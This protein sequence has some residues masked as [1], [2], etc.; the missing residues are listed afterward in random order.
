MAFFLNP[1]KS[2]I[3]WITFLFA[4]AFSSIGFIQAWLVNGEFCYALDDSF[5]MMALAKNLAFHQVWGLNQ[6]EFSSTASSP[7]FTVLLAAL[8]R[9]LGTNIFI[10]LIINIIALFFIF[11]YL[12]KKSGEWGLNAWQTWILLLGTFFFMPVP[13]LLFGSMEHLVHTLFALWVLFYVF[14][15]GTNSNPLKLFFGGLLLGAVRFEAMF[16]IGLLVLWLWK[17][18][19]WFLGFL[20]GIGGILSWLVLGIYSL[21]QG[22]FFLPNSLVLKAYGMNIQETGSFFGYLKSIVFK[23]ANHPHAIAS[24]F[25]LYLLWEWKIYKNQRDK[26]LIFVALGMSA[27]HFIFAR[28]NHVYRYEAYLMGISWVVCWKLVSSL[29]EMKTSKAFLQFF[30][31]K[32]FLPVLILVMIISPIYR[33]IDSYAVGTRAMC[34]IYDQQVQMAR[35]VEKYYP[36][37]TIGVL[38]IGALAFYSDCKIMDIWGLGTM[39]FAKLKLSGHYLPLKI[40]SVCKKKGMW[41]A[42]VYGIVLDHPD[43][44]KVRSWVISN[45]AVCSRERITFVCLDPKKEQDLLANLEAFEKNLPVSVKVSPE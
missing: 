14:E 8:F 13:V 16:E 22:W 15:N 17:E 29:S 2:K 3:T 26:E 4:L 41:L 45:N 24:S 19:A 23:A 7:F 38:D 27:M 33:S 43:W 10:P 34:N 25:S 39:E 5:I 1:K 42:I 31:K 35:F 6:Y 11:L 18:K 40:D 12:E 44:K 20:L 30:R 21:E 36:G 9:L 32:S 37:E 28:Y